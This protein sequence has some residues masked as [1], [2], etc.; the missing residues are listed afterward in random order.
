MS[1]FIP[2]RSRQDMRAAKRIEK[3]RDEFLNMREHIRN[4]NLDYKAMVDDAGIPLNHTASPTFKSYSQRNVSREYNFVKSIPV[5]IYNIDHRHEYDMDSGPNGRE[6]YIDC[7]YVYVWTYSPQGIPVIHEYIVGYTGVHTY[8]ATYS[9]FDV[10]DWDIDA[11][12]RAL[13]MYALTN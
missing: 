10:D 5:P 2:V 11:L 12:R 13:E 8:E 7:T 4:M 3:L 6:P 9:A 1:D